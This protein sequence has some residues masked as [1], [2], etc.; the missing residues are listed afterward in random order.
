M[1]DN[2]TLLASDDP[3]VTADHLRAALH[4]AEAAF[5]TSSDPTQINIGDEN[6]QWTI[7]HVPY[8]WTLILRGDECIGSAAVLPTS[9]EAM[10]LFLENKIEESA[11]FE[12]AQREV[13]DLRSFECLYLSGVTISPRHQKHGVG[14]LALTAT[15]EAALQVLPRARTIYCWPFNEM[16]A[17]LVRKVGAANGWEIIAKS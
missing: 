2:I 9:R 15:I 8:C 6:V 17:A 12:S 11:L 4:I 13:I 16:G 7:R 1:N 3:R 5:G 14:A 10:N